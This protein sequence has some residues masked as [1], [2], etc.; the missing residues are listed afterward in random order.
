MEGWAVV[1]VC[2]PRF[3]SCS[4]NEAAWCSFRLDIKTPRK[5]RSAGPLKIGKHLWLTACCGASVERSV[6]GS[7]R[8]PGPF[9]TFARDYDFAVLS[10]PAFAVVVIASFLSARLVRPCR[11]LRTCNYVPR[12][13][14]SVG[15]PHRNE[16]ARSTGLRSGFFSTMFFVGQRAH[17]ACS[18]QQ[19]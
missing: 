19:L 4:L 5:L 6:R 2:A 11:C 12:F 18:P 9:R 10:R 8:P 7:P 1:E 15:S 13:A 16:S 3:F 14:D 17:C